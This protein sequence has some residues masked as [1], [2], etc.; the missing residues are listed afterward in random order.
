MAERAGKH[1][2]EIIVVFKDP[3][4]IKQMIWVGLFAAI[5][6]V[7][8]LANIDYLK[9]TYPDPLRPPDRI[10]DWI[11][12]NTDFIQYGEYFS[13]AEIAVVIFF[14][15]AV[16]E[17]LRR[18]PKMLFLLCVMFTL[19]GFAITLTPME[20]ITPA[21][22][23]FAKSDFIVQTFY[24]GQFFSGHSSSALIQA[25]F[26][27]PYRV[28]GIRVTWFVLPLAV[29]QIVSILIY[30]G[31]YSIDIFAAFFVV[32]FLLTF[33]FL[34]LV[35]GWLRYVHWMPWY[36]SQPKT[37]YM[38]QSLVSEVSLSEQYSQTGIGDYD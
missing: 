22:E 11:P 13:R 14:F 38:P 31:H 32:Y 19:R 23:Y 16:P 9:S 20:D 18:F 17:R 30:H 25:F 35:P 28:R 5:M 10:L 7:T 33:D 37:E 2:R 29:G 12:Q 27:W 8:L 21:S 4:F 15:L 6:V 36:T 1:I 24:H 26:L 3:I 34:L